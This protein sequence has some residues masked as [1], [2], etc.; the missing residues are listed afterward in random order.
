M[1]TPRA[2]LPPD[3][4]VRIAI[5]KRCLPDREPWQMEQPE[6]FVYGVRPPTRSDWKNPDVWRAHVLRKLHLTEEDVK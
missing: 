4:R 3:R 1:S 2:K 5:F 6:L